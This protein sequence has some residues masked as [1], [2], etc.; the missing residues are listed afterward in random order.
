[1]RVWIVWEA[2]GKVPVV[3]YRESDAYEYRGRRTETVRH[4]VYIQSTLVTGEANVE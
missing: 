2:N 4:Q 1:M 3:F